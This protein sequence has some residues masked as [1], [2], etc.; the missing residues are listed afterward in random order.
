MQNF[1]IASAL[2]FALMKNLKIL[3]LIE[4]KVMTRQQFIQYFF[5]FHITRQ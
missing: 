5:Y 2:A 3:Q 4:L 1:P